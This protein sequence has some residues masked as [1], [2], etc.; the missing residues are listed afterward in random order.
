MLFES[1]Q[2]ENQDVVGGLNSFWIVP[3]G[4]LY[5]SIRG[6]GSSDYAAI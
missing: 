4:E 3:L 6:V 5:C 2:L 1:H